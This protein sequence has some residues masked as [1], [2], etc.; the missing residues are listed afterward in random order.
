MLTHAYWQRKFG[1]DPAIIGRRIDVD[2]VPREIVGVL[3]PGFS[4]LDQHPQLVLPLR[5][6]RAKTFVGN[7]SFQAVGRLKPGVT[8]S[9]A[10]ADIAR[11]LPLVVERFP[12]PGGFTRQ[13]FD[14]VKLGPN[15][16]PLAADVIGDVGR[17]LWVLLGTVGIVLLIACANVANLFLVRAEGR[18]QE[19]AIHAAL[20]ASR[21]QV[22]WELLSESLTLACLGGIGGVLVA[23]AGIRGLIAMAPEGLPRVDA[24]SID[25]TVLLFALGVSLASGLLFG[26]IPMM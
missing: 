4:F 11:M 13:M 24:I 12:L 18:Q 8:I 19:L 26:S 21:R 2:G 6:D 9:Q 1:Q 7:F 10:N 15:V 16:R 23:A 20:G 5:F 3:P 17:T 25:P 14:E 22:A